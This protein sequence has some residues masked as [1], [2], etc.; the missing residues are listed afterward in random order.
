[1]R[2]RDYDED[3]VVFARRKAAAL[4]DSHRA[5]LHISADGYER[6]RAIAAGWDVYALETEWREW[7]L[8]T[9][10]PPPDQT[11]AAFVGFVKEW[12]R[13]HGRPGSTPDDHEAA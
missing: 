9:G 1:M 3:M 7:Q 12:V 4:M 8:K 11:D 6:A 10:K 2:W 13:R 5:V